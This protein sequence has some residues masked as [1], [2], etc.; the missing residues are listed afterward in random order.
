MEPAAE[1]RVHQHARL[2]EGHVHLGLQHADC[3]PLVQHLAGGVVDEEVPQGG[4]HQHAGG[5]QG[6]ACLTDLW[7]LQAQGLHSQQGVGQL[8]LLGT[9]THGVH[10]DVL[11]ASQL[12]NGGGEEVIE[13]HVAVLGCISSGKGGAAAPPAAVAARQHAAIHSQVGVQDLH[14]LP[15]LPYDEGVALHACVLGLV[16]HHVGQAHSGG[17]VEQQH[18]QQR[19]GQQGPGLPLLLAPVHGLHEVQNLLGAQVLV[20]ILVD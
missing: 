1:P 12:H 8:A 19:N 5:E 9:A 11:H 3:G 18:H 10:R 7:G 20:A 16:N 4:H 15:G 6:R 14:R 13:A 17:H 2:Y